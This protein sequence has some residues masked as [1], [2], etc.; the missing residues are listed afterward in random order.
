MPSCSAGRFRSS[1]REDLAVPVR[2]RPAHK[3]GAASHP[4]ETSPDVLGND[5]A[6]RSGINEKEARKRA[7]HAASGEGT[8]PAAPA[9]R[10]ARSASTPTWASGPS[11]RRPPPQSKAG[12]DGLASASARPFLRS[13]QSAARSAC[14]KAWNLCAGWPVWPTLQRSPPPGL[15]HPRPPRL[16]AQNDNSVCVS[17]RPSGQRLQHRTKASLAPACEDSGC[18]P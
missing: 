2:G 18:S 13:G 11:T 3:G 17:A 16:C 7:R 8:A 14:P 4:R 9:S 1:P 5:C 6:L 15:P 12:R 10:R